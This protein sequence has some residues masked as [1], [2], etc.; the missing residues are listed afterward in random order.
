[1]RNFT[2]ILLIFLL[3]AG[4]S[5]AQEILT[6]EKCLDIALENNLQIKRSENNLL[7]AKSNKAQAIGNFLPSVNANIG[8]D[9]FFGT[10]FDQNA[11]RQVTETTNRSNPNI[12]A[13][14]T[15]FNGFSNTYE[16]NR[17]NLELKAAESNVESD[18][19]NTKSSVYNAYLSIILDQE[20]IKISKERMDLLQQQL[21]REIQR[22]RVGVS[23][24]ETVYNF[25]SQLANEKLSNVNLQNRL[26]SDKLI[27][28]QLLRLDVSGN[29][30][31]AT[32]TSDDAILLEV[33]PFS[34]I[35]TKSL[36]FSPAIRAAQLN[37]DASRLSFKE[38]AAAR[39]PTISAFATV[40]SNYSSNGAVNP[41]GNVFESDASFFDQLGYNQF[42]YVG[43]NMNIPIFNNFRTSN[44][45][46][47]AK[48]G[49]YNSELDVE[50]AYQTV[51][52][53]LQQTYL[54]LVAA[55]ETYSAALENLES[56][57]QSFEFVKKRYEEGLT[58]FYTY[59]ESLNNKN[60]AQIE[61]ANAKYSIVFRKKILDLLQG[62]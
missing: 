44:S 29:Y 8:Y 60:R 46:Q 59:L 28:F 47:T 53:T 38:S 42:E 36:I 10:T 23:N 41:D 51:T 43:F 52:N 33:A 5:H 57:D 39:Y 40:G 7:I 26:K 19:V 25:K 32:F 12:S 13:N 54:D 55:Q 15:I 9:Y 35:L 11:A 56:L 2:I 62:I 34:G 3:P 48:L 22:E 49:Y 1:M 6:L 21:E 45:I 20:N 50:Q 31:V 30:E 18:K 24:M 16:F 17:R 37:K 27:L 58:D 4:L 14:W 61:L